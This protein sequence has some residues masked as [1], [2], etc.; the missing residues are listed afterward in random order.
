MKPPWPVLLG[1]YS[2]LQSGTTVHQWIESNEVLSL[3][4]DARRFVSFGIIKG[5]LRRVHRWPFLIDRKSPLIGPPEPS[6]RKVEFDKRAALFGSGTNLSTKGGLTRSGPG[7]STFTLRSTESHNS[8]L[9]PSSFVRTPPSATRSPARRPGALTN[10][11]DSYPRSLG[12]AAETHL[13]TGSKRGNLRSAAIRIREAES[14]AL[15]EE[16]IRYL[17]GMHHA[18]EIQVRFRLGWKE[19]EKILG[20]GEVGGKGKKGVAIIYR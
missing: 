1:L 20:V 6:K 8:G 9:S 3:G 19:L 17:D 10:M 11:R 4:I 12:S 13:S 18:D 7:D 16:L 14:R 15:E 5:F 2:K